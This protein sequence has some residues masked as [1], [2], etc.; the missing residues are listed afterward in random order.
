MYVGDYNS[1]AIDRFAQEKSQ[2]AL[3]DTV[4]MVVLDRS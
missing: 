4:R 2:K 1:R 3:T